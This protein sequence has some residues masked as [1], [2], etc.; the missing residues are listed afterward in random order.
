MTGHQLL[1]TLVAL[2]RDDRRLADRLTLE[3]IPADLR[4]LSPL[5]PSADLHHLNIPQPVDEP[6][7]LRLEVTA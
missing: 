3:S 6:V 4:Y 1:R 2:D 7:Q 5:A